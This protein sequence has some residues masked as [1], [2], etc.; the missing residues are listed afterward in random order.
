MVANPKALL[1]APAPLFAL[2]AIVL[3]RPSLGWSDVAISLST[4]FIFSYGL[5]IAGFPLHLI[6]RRL[7]RIDFASYLLA[8]W[9]ALAVVIV[10]LTLAEGLPA[11]PTPNDNSPFAA[12][13]LRSGG[14]ILS[15]LFGMPV[16]SGI[17]WVFWRFAASSRTNAGS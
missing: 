7:Q 1:A 9:F 5:L 8:F 13:T 2:L 11:P 12:M 3:A 6:L 4:A 16:V 15:L 10:V 17:A 14:W